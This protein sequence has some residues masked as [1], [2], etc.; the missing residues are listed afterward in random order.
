MRVRASIYCTQSTIFIHYSNKSDF[1]LVNKSRYV[2]KYFLTLKAGTC[3]MNDH[4]NKL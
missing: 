2:R 1:W 4:S 3:I